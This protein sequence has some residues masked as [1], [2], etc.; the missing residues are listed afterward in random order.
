MELPAL[1]VLA[2]RAFG[3]AGWQAI[4]IQR[5]LGAPTAGLVGQRRAGVEG[6]GERLFHAHALTASA[7]RPKRAMLRSASAWLRALRSAR[8]EIGRASC[9]GRVCQDVWISVGAGS[10]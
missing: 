2:G 5:T 3:V 4:D 7:S 1:Y 10:L 8:P 6:D 9:R